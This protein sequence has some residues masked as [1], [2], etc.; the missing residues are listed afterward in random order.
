MNNFDPETGVSSL[1]PVSDSTD[2]GLVAVVPAVRV[3]LAGPPVE[4][5]AARS[6]A[7]DLRV[8]YHESGHTVV[9]RVLGDEVCGVTI[10]PDNECSGKTWGPRALHAAAVWNADSLFDPGMPRDGDIGGVFSVVQQGVIAMMAGCAAEMVFLGDA[11]PKYIA[12]DVPQASRF[13]GVICRTVASADAFVE[14]CYQ[15]SLALVEQHRTVIHAVAQALLAHPKRTLNGDEIDAVIAPAL[16]AK[17]ADDERKRRADWAKVLKNSADF[18]AG[19][20][21]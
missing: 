3:G 19:L 1:S 18:A 2:E 20:E 4:T 6:A 21:N 13:A 16:A 17:A 5:L 8:A 12:N 14:H 15:E 7:D 10:V 11:P 9:H